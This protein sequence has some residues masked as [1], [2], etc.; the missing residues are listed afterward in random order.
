MSEVSVEGLP[1]ADAVE[2][3]RCRYCCKSVPS[4]GGLICYGWND[5]GVYC[6]PYGYCYKGRRGEKVE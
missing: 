5:S 1:P 6:S 4:K 3:V 2:P